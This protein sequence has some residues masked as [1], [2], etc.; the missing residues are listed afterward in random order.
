MSPPRATSWLTF[1]GVL[2]PAVAVL[3]AALW[4]ARENRGAVGLPATDGAVAFLADAGRGLD[5]GAVRA[6][7]A[8]AWQPG[9]DATRG[10]RGRGVWWTRV[11]LRNP[12]A[13]PWHGVL[14]ARSAFTDR[15][16]AWTLAGNT[17]QRRE[18]GEATPQRERPLRGREIALAGDVPAHGETVVFFRSE[19]RFV[20]WHGW[21]WWR[22]AADFSAARERIVVGEAVFFGALLAL[23]AYNALLWWR[24][25]LADIGFYVL[26]GATVALFLLLVR[27][28][29]AAAGWTM[30]SPALETALAV[31]LALSAFFLTQ[32]AR[33]FL[34]T[35]RW[36]P[37]ADQAMR[38]VGWAMLALAAAGLTTPWWE[39][40]HGFALAVLADAVLH[41][42][43]FALALAAWRAG[44]AQ[45]RFF[46]QSFGC[47]FAGSLVA[48]ATWWWRAGEEVPL[49]G[50][51]LGSALEMLLL[52][53]AVAERF[54]QAQREKAEAQ[55]RLAGETERRR[56]LQEAYADEL[57][58]EVRDR[59]RE[60]EQANA[61][62]DRMLAVI[63]HDLRSPIAGLMRAAEAERGTFAHE[64]L[65]TGRAVLLLIEDLVLWARLRAGTRQIAAHPAANIIAPA[66]ALHRSLAASG[67]VE[68]V[69]H[70]PEELRVETE[71]VLA[72]TL[73]RNLLA[74]G[75][76]F[77]ERR[78]VLSVARAGAGGVRVTI[79]ND[80]PPLSPAVA[81]RLAT[82]E[83]EP[84]TATGGLG[85]RLC[86]E[87]CQALGSRL[88][89]G[90][91]ADGCTEFGC[92]LREAGEGAR[93][94][95]P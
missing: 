52:S 59:T 70:V 73:V 68:L 47:L 12:T 85:L 80:G 23:L 5:F 82:G 56:A 75:L 42:A 77:A 2:A 69:V 66:V 28:W 36:L 39:R 26:H 93:R 10:W 17:W 63:G 54:A 8:D 86:R 19:D 81:V 45:A 21:L 57:E 25:R 62:K 44:A 46:V 1:V 76:K 15:V 79:A 83:H 43:W 32:F 60:L 50:L 58:A 71:L 35:A 6:L 11:T 48:M 67:G 89:A 7:P 84:L 27:A 61:D 24:L 88:E 94:N 40:A 18:L 53:R 87:I 55:E 92:T 65:R 34:E 14:A 13:Q 74:N 38:V 22:D 33:A 78:V 9:P 31:T 90:V 16:E 41:V 64:T 72:Q 29:P 51:M 3:V 95:L 4:L 91:T 49:G 20:T 37:R 30:A